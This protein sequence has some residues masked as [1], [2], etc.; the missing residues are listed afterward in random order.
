M[1]H[2]RVIDDLCH[3]SQP[4]TPRGLKFDRSGLQFGSQE[5]ELGKGRRKLPSKC[6]KAEQV[7]Q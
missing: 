7:K 5:P 2:N 4:L 6:P 3:F 1:L